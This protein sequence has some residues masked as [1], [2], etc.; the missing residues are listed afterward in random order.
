[1]ITLGK[2]TPLNYFQIWQ[3]RFH[4]NK[5]LLAAHKVG[6]HNKIVFTKDPQMGTAPYYISGTKVKRAKKEHNG[7]ITVYAVPIEDLQ[8][9]ELNEKDI[10]SLV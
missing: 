8:P 10:R 5:V 3:R 6:T 9:L 2:Y 1:M 7:K 4:D